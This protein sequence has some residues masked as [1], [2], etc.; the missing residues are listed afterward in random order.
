[1]TRLEQKVAVVTGAASGIGRSIAELFAEHGA[2]VV[3]ADVNQEKGSKLAD[4]LLASGCK[5]IF[6]P[7]DVTQPLQVKDLI[8][9]TINEF[10]ALQI[11]VNNAAVWDGDTTITDLSEDTWH[12]V[13]D[14]TLKSVY[15]CTKHA[16]PEMIRSG[17]GSIINISSV[18]AIYG[19]GLSAYT[20]AKGGVVALTRLVAAEFGDRNIRANAILPGTIGTDSAL[21]V[22]K[23][24][25]QAFEEIKKAHPVGRI[26][27]PIDVAYCAL[28][29]AS[30]EAAFVT[31]GVFVID[32]GLTAGKKLGF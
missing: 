10:G 28:Y 25:L 23:T 17:G 32:G 9:E 7:T 18:N 16:M 5:A 21:A 8:S 26:G 19:V 3:I 29:L 24:N 22:W 20:A 1:M 12:R 4:D 27:H 15:L 13:I 31:G 6:I 14:G 2:K 11:L 30:S